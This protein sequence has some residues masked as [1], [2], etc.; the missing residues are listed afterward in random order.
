MNA[1]KLMAVPNGNKYISWTVRILLMLIIGLFFMFSLDVFD[2][3]AGEPLLAIVKGFL[4]HNTFT[5]V[6]L[7]ILA[8]TWRWEHIG[9]LLLIG[10]G[11][12]M[13]FFFGGPA[14]LF[15]DARWA[16]VLTPIPIGILL[17]VNHFIIGRSR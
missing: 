16:L 12:Y 2:M 3:R 11:I 15:D 5:F 8:V 10:T 6:L 9:G 13:V 7:L 14:H 4:I 1:F 17:I